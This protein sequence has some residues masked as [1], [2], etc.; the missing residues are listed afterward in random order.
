MGAADRDIADQGSWRLSTRAESH[1]N[2][3]SNGPGR[4]SGSSFNAPTADQRERYNA[5]R[6]SE[7]RRVFQRTLPMH[8]HGISWRRTVLWVR[9]RETP[10]LTKD[11]S[12]W[13]PSPIISRLTNQSHRRRAETRR[14]ECD[15]DTGDGRG[16]WRRSF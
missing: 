16:S 2:E 14:R 8:V 7:G 13:I 1:R 11:Q 5:A 4:E 3:E 15:G 10:T 6:G 12:R 9:T